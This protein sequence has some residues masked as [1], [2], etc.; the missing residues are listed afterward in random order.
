MTQQSIGWIGAGKMGGPMSARLVAAGHRVL[1]V[2]PDQGNC[3][4]AKAAGAEIALDL[5]TIAAEADILF[6]MIPNDAVLSG[7]VS[8][9]DGLASVMAPGSILV[10][11]ST[12]SPAASK[13]VAELLAARGI[14]YLRA[15][16]SGSTTMASAGTLSVMASGPRDVYDRVEPLLAAF[17]A[18]RFYVGKAEQARYLKLVVNTLVGAT[19][20]I[21][22]E[23]LAFGRKGDLTLDDMLMVISQSAVASPLIGYKKDMVVSGDYTPAFTVEQM[24]KDF[25]LIMNTAKQDHVPMYVAALVRQQYEQAFAQGQAQ[26]D[27]FVLCETAMRDKAAAE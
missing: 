22:A 24:I 11:M 6:S 8:D 15:P 20:S 5:K 2:D 25:D 1:V 17:S 10:E 14:G 7:I 16:V 23:A 21:L 13:A 27:F 12:V 9:P 4:I 26:K 18:K 19:S 3:D